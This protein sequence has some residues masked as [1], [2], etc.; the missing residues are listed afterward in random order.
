MEA[1][2]EIL[3]AVPGVEFVDLHQPAVGLQSVNLSVLPA[4]RREQQLKE[5]QGPFRAPISL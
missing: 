3:Q 2:I 4:L 5:L 1:A